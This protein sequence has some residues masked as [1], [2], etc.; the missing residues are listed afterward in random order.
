MERGSGDCARAAAARKAYLVSVLN[1]VT[2]LIMRTPGNSG[3]PNLNIGRKGK[4]VKLLV[5]YEAGFTLE[6]RA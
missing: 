2:N 3:Y 6:P 4:I 1:T 5:A